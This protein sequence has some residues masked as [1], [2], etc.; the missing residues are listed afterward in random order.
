M[1]VVRSRQAEADLV[2]IWNAIARDNL[3][4]ADRLLDEFE[5]RGTNLVQHSMIARLR[6]EIGPDVR[7][8]VVGNYLILYRATATEVEI[9]RYVHGRRDL[10]NVV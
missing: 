6:P 1:R 9:V 8:V 5:R 2:D 7:A 4:A 10:R 3:T